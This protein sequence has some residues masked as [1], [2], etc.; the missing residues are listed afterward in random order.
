MNELAKSDPEL[1]ESIWV[2]NSFFFKKLTGG[3]KCAPVVIL[4]LLLLT[5][6]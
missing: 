6:H 5:V 1:A 2:F 3:K 4:K